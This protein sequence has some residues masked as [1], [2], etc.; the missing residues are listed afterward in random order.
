MA[1]AYVRNLE[2]GEAFQLHEIVAITPGS[3]PPRPHPRP[4][5]PDD[6]RPS[7]PIALPGDPWWGDNLQPEHPIV[8]PPDGEQPPDPPP[9]SSGMNCR[10]GYTDQ[11]WVLF[12]VAG[13]YD[14]PRPQR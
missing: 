7:H 10:W 14:K 9:G 12:C 13:P 1:L 3:P 8:L 4:P 5:G 11:G 2:T 6:P